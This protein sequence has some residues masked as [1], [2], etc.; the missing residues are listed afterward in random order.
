MKY[1]V[2]VNQKFLVKVE[3]DGSMLASEHYIL[4]NFQGIVGAQAF[5][6][7]GLKTDTFA[8]A[9]ACS[10]TIS[11]DEL[12]AMSDRYENAYIE[13]A[14]K[15]DDEEA[16]KNEIEQLQEIIERKKAELNT[17]HF[18]TRKAHLEALNAKNALNCIEH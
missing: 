6:R 4:D 16:M 12:K 13:L 5:D 8:G 7:D 1:M 9:V 2:W 3:V 11:L 10:D 18:A 17:K 14:K 15:Q